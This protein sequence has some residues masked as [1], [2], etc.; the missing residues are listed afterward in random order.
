MSDNRKPRKKVGTYKIKQKNIV[1]LNKFY[2]KIKKEWQ[3][4]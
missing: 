1:N 3:I 4:I 2:E